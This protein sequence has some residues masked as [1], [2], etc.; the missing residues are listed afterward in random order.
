M[1]KLVLVTGFGYYGKYWFNPSGEV[2]QL[3]SGREVRG[4]TIVSHVMPVSIRVVRSELPR[5]LEELSPRLIIGLGLAPE[6]T[7]LSLELA[8]VNAAYFP[9]GDIESYRADYEPVVEGG[10]FVAYTTLPIKHI[11]SEC[12]DKKLLPLRPSLS[13]GLYLCNAAAYIIMSYGLKHNALAGF[14]HVPPSTV[15]YL[16]G[17]SSHGVPLTTIAEAVE[18]IIDASLQWL[19]SHSGSS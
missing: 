2:A 6:A 7:E 13:T 10:S 17:E 11:L 14:V 18:C 16:R 4:Y 1:R 3:L 9:K 15:N 19:E 8:A 5:I 12:R